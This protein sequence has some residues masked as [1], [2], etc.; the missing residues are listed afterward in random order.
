MSKSY[1]PFLKPSKQTW[2]PWNKLTTRSFSQDLNKVLRSSR[3]KSPSMQKIAVHNSLQISPI[4]PKPPKHSQDNSPTFS[5]DSSCNISADFYFRLPSFVKDLDSDRTRPKTARSKRNVEVGETPDSF[6]ENYHPINRGYSKE[7]AGSMLKKKLEPRQIKIVFKSFQTKRSLSPK[8]RP[9][10]YYS[11][12][13]LQ[14]K[15]SARKEEP[16][17]VGSKVKRYYME[18]PMTERERHRD[19]TRTDIF[20]TDEMFMMPK[21]SV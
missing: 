6:I 15:E 1:Y 12:R 4:K 7:Q 5:I 18:K 19:S 21:F 8:K 11:A 3:A 16:V 10:E 2:V 17:V 13:K 20:M 9:M 14:N